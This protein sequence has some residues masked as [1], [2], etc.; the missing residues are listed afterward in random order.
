MKYKP[1]I[2]NLLSQEGRAELTMTTSSVDTRDLDIPV[3]AK[4]TL[5]TQYFNTLLLSKNTKNATRYEI[6]SQEIDVNDTTVHLRVLEDAPL[7]SPLTKFWKDVGEFIAFIYIPLSLVAG[8]VAKHLYEREHHSKQRRY[9]RFFSEPR[10]R[11][12]H[13]GEQQE[14]KRERRKFGFRRKERI[15]SGSVKAN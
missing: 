12:S 3:N 11:N 9:K 1:T 14:T 8:W 10:K 15:H 5:P 7:W 13:E 2:L 4:V 6:P